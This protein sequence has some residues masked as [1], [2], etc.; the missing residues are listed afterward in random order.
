MK[1][2]IT[3]TKIF[4]QLAT[5]LFVAGFCSIAQAQIVVNMKVNSSQ[6]KLTITTHGTC[7]RQPNPA[8]CVRASGRTQINFNLVE[9]TQCNAGG[10]WELT[11]VALGNSSGRPGN[12]SA[13]AAGDFNA[14]QGSGVVTPV[15]RNARHISVRDDNSQAY[16]IWYTVYA[17]CAASGSTIDSDPRIENTGTGT[18]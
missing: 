3:D 6:N 2:Q 12:I 7:A 18:N 17:T 11:H 8:G 5:V 4:L 9:N 16:D 14:N 15:S 1:K 13:V 10:N